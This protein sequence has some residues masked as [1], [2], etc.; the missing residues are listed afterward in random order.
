MTPF[1]NTIHCVMHF[2]LNL[3]LF[4]NLID[5]RHVVVNLF[6]TYFQVISVEVINTF[7]VICL[8]TI[9]SNR[10]TSF[11]FLFRAGNSFPGDFE[12]INSFFISR[13]SLDFSVVVYFWICFPWQIT[14][15]YW[16]FAFS[17]I[18]KYD[19]GFIHLS[20]PMY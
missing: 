11:A 16:N 17:V 18:R 20:T 8:F 1:S 10:L 19:F 7:I 14:P 2:F 15:L 12:H 6:G 13:T 5:L 9:S 4:Q 3:E